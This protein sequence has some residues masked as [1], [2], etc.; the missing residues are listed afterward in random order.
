MLEHMSVVWCNKD[1][2]IFNFLIKW[3]AN[4]IKGKKNTSC[5]Y[6]KGVQ[7]AGKTMP[8]DFMRFHVLG[9]SLCVETGSNPLKTKFNSELAGKLL[10]SFEELE[11]FS[12]TE[13]MSI[14]SVLKRI[15]TSPTIMIEGKGLDPV[16][17]ININNYFLISNNDAIQDDD[18][19]RYFILPINP[20]FVGNFEYFETL[21]KDCFNDIVG[22]AFY[23]Y[24]TEVD[25]NNFNAQRYPITSSKKDSCAK[26]LDSVYRFIKDVYI[27]QEL[28]IVK[29]KVFDI[30]ED[31]CSY[32]KLK[33]TKPKLKIDFCN[34]LQNVGINKKKISGYWYYKESWEDLKTIANKFNWIHELDEPQYEETKTD[35]KIN[36][37]YKKILKLEK[38]RQKL[39]NEQ[40]NQYE[41]IQS[42][43]IEEVK[44]ENF[45]DSIEHCISSFIELVE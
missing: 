10:V 29:I 35:D 28:S 4:M 34:T 22:H 7:G 3:L 39:K 14:S 31:Y 2:T 30:Y 37:E 40:N 27:L 23:C 11:N 5:I 6:L 12:T 1:K 26:R 41:Q 45:G 16:E 13:W 32:C 24:L 17:H 38:L 18:G 36:N 19:R 44:I 25:T 9:E 21:G 8:I 42:L 15:I 43:K 33:D 20:C